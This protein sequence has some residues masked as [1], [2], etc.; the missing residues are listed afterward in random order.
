MRKS[1]CTQELYTNHCIANPSR[2]SC[3]E[4]SKVSPDRMSHDTASRYL[5]TAELTEQMFS[6]LSQR[7][8]NLIGGY[9]VLDDT[10]LDKPYAKKM[11]LVK[12][13]YSGKHHRTV[14]GICLVTL[15]WTDGEKRIPIAYRIYAPDV[16]G[17]TKNDHARDMLAQAHQRGFQPKAVLMDSWYTSLENLHVIRELGWH[18]LGSLKCNRLLSNERRQHIPVV[19]LDWTAP[20]SVHHLWLKG[21]DFVRVSKIE[22][23]DGHIAYVATDNL[24]LQSYD[25][26]KACA[27]HRW[28]IEAF[29]R[30]VK[31][32]CGI[33]RC[34]SVL[35]RSQRNHIFCALLAFI[36]LECQRVISGLSCYE[37]KQQIVRGAVRGFLANA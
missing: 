4:L 25:D 16:D 5:S 20:H 2:Y 36:K 24:S 37:F 6:E 3:S 18:W 19:E 15:L 29:H 35:E 32:C 8:L 26:I 7:P 34:Y 21:Y 14:K 23:P 11:A 22:T 31:Q 12:K 30:T 1:K 13:Q 10:L 17:K 9:L 27:N 28:A 33:E